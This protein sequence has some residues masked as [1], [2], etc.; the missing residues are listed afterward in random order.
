[1]KR[2]RFA[3][4]KHKN[5]YKPKANC[6]K[7]NGMML[8]VIHDPLVTSHFKSMFREYIVPFNCIT[9]QVFLPRDSYGGLC[10]NGLKSELVLLLDLY[11][12]D[13][14]GNFNDATTG[15]GSKNPIPNKSQSFGRYCMFDSQTCIETMGTDSVLSTFSIATM[16]NLSNAHVINHSFARSKIDFRSRANFTTHVTTWATKKNLLLSIILVG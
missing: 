4:S 12:L 7:M 8:G 16:E 13:V 1:M 2:T 10:Q 14:V 9:G 11:I 15:Y 6:V 5:G 3:C